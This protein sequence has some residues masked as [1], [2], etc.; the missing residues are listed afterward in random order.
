VYFLQNRQEDV[1]TT[2]IKD[3]WRWALLNLFALV[4]MAHMLR[5]A[6]QLNRFRTDFGPLIDSGKWAIR[7]LLFSLAITP[8]NTVFGWRAGIKLRKPAGLWAFAFGTLHFALYLYD[9]DGDWLQYPIPD[10]MAG[11]GVA[12]ILILAALASTSTRW[13]MKRLGKNWKRLH[14]LVYAAGIIAIA[15]GLLES[16]SSKRV[17]LTDP[18]ARYEVILYGLLLVVLLALR[19]NI[20]RSGISSL[21]HR[22]TLINK[23]PKPFVGLD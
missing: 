9:M 11:L 8:L 4:V 20:V 14:R 23:K 3:N 17:F 13:A 5:S 10:Y 7:F 22:L 1:V 12:A 16:I 19:I 2:W 15:H 18:D 6:S 21:R